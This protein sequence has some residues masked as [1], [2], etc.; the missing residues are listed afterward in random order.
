MEDDTL[1]GPLSAGHAESF[2][3]GDADTNGSLDLSDAVRSLS[4]LFLGTPS[5]LDCEKSADSD[6]TG[7]LDISDPIYLLDFLFLGGPA[8]PSP[9]PHCGTDPENSALGCESYS[10]CD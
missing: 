8:P 3:R 4:Y 2:I 5:R 6:S 9:F 7:I 1:A 10:G